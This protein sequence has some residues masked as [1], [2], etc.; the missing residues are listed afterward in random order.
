MVKK[1]NIFESSD[2]RKDSDEGYHREKF[3]YTLTIK[4]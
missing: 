4:T 2:D 3:L 1:E